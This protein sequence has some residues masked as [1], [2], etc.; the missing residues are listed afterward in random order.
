MG[1]RY[2]IDT[3]VISHLFADRLPQTG[4]TFVTEIVNEEFIISVAVEIEVLNYH[5]TP[6]KCRSLKSSSIL[7][8]FY[9]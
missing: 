2:L 1:Q 4:K 6:N 8:L 9:R 5:E 7:L 3:N